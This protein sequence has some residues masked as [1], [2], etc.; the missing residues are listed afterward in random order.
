MAKA[1]ARARSEQRNTSRC[2]VESSRHFGQHRDDFD[3]AVAAWDHRVQTGQRGNQMSGF[4]NRFGRQRALEMFADWTE[5][6][7]AGELPPVPPR[8][9]GLERNVVITLWDWGSEIEY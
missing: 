9:Q 1:M 2:A 8:P 6:I 4:M 3:S 5:R 7:A